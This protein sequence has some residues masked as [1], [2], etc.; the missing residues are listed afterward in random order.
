MIK[1]PQL[2]ELKNFATQLKFDLINLMN[3]YRN[4]SDDGARKLYSKTTSC[5]F[6][7]HFPNKLLRI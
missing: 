4:L 6:Q 1:K 5:L 3:T 7:N 2:S